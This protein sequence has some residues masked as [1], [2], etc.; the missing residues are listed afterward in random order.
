M[1]SPQCGRGGSYW[2]ASFSASYTFI[3]A[4][5]LASLLRSRRL[6]LK[7]ARPIAAEMVVIG[8]PLLNHV[9]CAQQTRLDD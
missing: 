4:P 3:P 2:L 6:R 9:V 5:P 7:I 8:G 1:Q